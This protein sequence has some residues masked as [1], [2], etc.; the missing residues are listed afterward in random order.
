MGIEEGSNSGRQFPVEEE[1][2][3]SVVTG[4]RWKKTGNWGPLVSE[5]KREGC[6]GSGFSFL[7]CGLV[8]LLGRK[9]SRGPVS[10]FYF[11]S[12]FFFFCFLYFFCI[13]CIHYPN[14]V[15]PISKFL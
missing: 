13:F 2:V 12:S 3:T 6:T 15:K 8:P 11:F 14:K 9:G 7:G 1:T 5:W 10:Y 4:Q